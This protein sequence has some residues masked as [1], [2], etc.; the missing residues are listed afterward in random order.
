MFIREFEIESVP[1]MC[2]SRI[3]SMTSQLVVCEVIVRCAS[4]IFTV[5][6]PFRHMID[7]TRMFDFPTTRRATGVE[8]E[9][10]EA[11][12]GTP[13]VGTHDGVQDEIDGVL[14]PVDHVQDD[15]SWD[16]CAVHG[17]AQKHVVDADR[18]HTDKEQQHECED[19]DA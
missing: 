14:E 19:D 18:D 2:L 11:T 12:I 8:E 9:A 6:F 1:C 13:E 15:A 17:V 5:P 7:T 4:A 10:E 16:A 3:R